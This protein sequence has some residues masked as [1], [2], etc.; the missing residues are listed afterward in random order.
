MTDE[1]LVELVE[2]D[3]ARETSERIRKIEIAGSRSIS[4]A[5][6]DTSRLNNSS[7]AL[8]VSHQNAIHRQVGRMATS[9][10]CNKRIA[11]PPVDTA[12]YIIRNGIRNSEFER[13]AVQRCSGAAVQSWRGAGG[14]EFAGS[15]ERIKDERTGLPE[16]RKRRSYKLRSHCLSGNVI[17]GISVSGQL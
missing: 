1:K 3:V 11:G 2:R 8:H 4:F 9:L 5:E 17:G 12:L 13:A 6:V 10:R 7:R 16:T 14:E 15:Q